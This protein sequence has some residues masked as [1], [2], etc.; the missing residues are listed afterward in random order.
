MDEKK[1]NRFQ[2]FIEHYNIA[3]ENAIKGDR[4][5]VEG[6][7]EHAEKI[8]S[9]LRKSIYDVLVNEE[10]K[11]IPLLFNTDS[12]HWQSDPGHAWLAVPVNHLVAMKIE[13]SI[14]SCS[15]LSEDGKT[16]YLEEDCDVGIFLYGFL[17]RV[18]VKKK[19]KDLKD[20][21][22]E[23]SFVRQLPS[24][25]WGKIKPSDELARF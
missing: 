22:L 24:Y 8:L 13:K 16:A 21:F 17:N 15:Y 14:S 25:Y 4:N 5:A 3:L 10:K 2:D 19:I 18:E 12:Y 9:S 1:V 20:N 6:H 11:D 23:E 7:I